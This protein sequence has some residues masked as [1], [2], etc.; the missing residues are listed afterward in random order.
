MREETM[1]ARL[2]SGV[3]GPGT[4]AV[5]FTG[6]G[7]LPSAFAVTEFAAAS[8]GVAGA[9]VA[10]L[11]QRLNA[12]AAGEPGPGPV[13][14]DRGLASLWFGQSF[15]PVGWELPPAWDAIAGDYE[16]AD[17]WI[18]LHTNAPHHRLAALGVLGLDA[19][20]ASRE[21]VAAEV[22]A[23]AGAELESAVVA[24]GGCAA[25]MRSASQWAMHCQGAAVAAEPL[26]HWRLTGSV[27][28]EG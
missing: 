25:Q 12:A 20:T 8:V 15:R 3:G 14:V 4:A 1:L 5:S 18:R 23:W 28:R 22:A 9:A 27:R 10:E 26:L 7:S 17:S 6:S 24:A 2:W 21:P 13:Q 16:C 11:A 19:A